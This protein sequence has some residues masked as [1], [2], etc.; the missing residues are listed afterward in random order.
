MTSPI[1]AGW[2]TISPAWSSSS[3]AWATRSRL[4]PRPPK[5]VYTLGDRFIRIGTPRP[6]PVSGSIARITLSVRLESQI[7]E[8]FEREKFDICH[9]HEPLMPTLC[10]TVLRLKR[11]ADGRHFSRL[12]RQALVHHVLAHHEMVPRPVVPQAG[13]HGLPCLRWLTTTSISISRRIHHHPQ[14][15]RYPSFQQPRHAIR[16]ISGR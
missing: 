7:K 3:P 4:S 13:R 8:V 12:R 2:S 16:I 11:C 9:L 5:A 1:P 14:R 15:H 10:T 6:V